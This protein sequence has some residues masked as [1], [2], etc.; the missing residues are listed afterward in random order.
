MTPTFDLADAVVAT[1]T[2]NNR[3]TVFLFEKLSSE[4][5]HMVVPVTRPNRLNPQNTAGFEAPGS[6]TLEGILS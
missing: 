4:V 2:T 6:V 3:V 1:W 5:W